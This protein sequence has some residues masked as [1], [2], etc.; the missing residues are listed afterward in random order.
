MESPGGVGRNIAENL[1]R[2]GIDTH[3]ITAFGSDASGRWLAEEC[4]ADGIRTAGSLTVEQ[5]PGSRYLAVMDD[6]GDL[7]VAVSDMRALD[8][9]TPAVLAE[10]T[11][12]I[13]QATVV[14]ADAN[15]SAESLE[16]LAREVRAPLLVDL[17]SSAKAGRAVG[18]LQGIHTL[19]LNTLEAAAVLGHDVEARD[20]ADVARAAAQLIAMGVDRV[21]LTRGE[22]G[23]IA[24]DGAQGITLPGPRPG[25]STPPRTG[26]AF[27]AG[28]ACGM[29]MQ[30][31]LRQTAALGSAMA[32]SALTSERTVNAGLDLPTVLA[33]MK[34]LLR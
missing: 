28:V 19:K 21:F 17:V 20:D 30:L 7:A 2:L 27:S 16:W 14:V 15:L 29:L 12:L 6:R 32:E 22:L 10:R 25:S 8:A 11:D 18:A 4:A 26:D 23:V 1:A 9:L 3:L 13:R 24:H 5:V 31:D 33:A 34:E